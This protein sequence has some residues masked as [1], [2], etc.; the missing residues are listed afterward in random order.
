[1]L[2]LCAC[3]RRPAPPAELRAVCGISKLIERSRATHSVAFRFS[4]RARLG[5]LRIATPRHHPRSS[6]CLNAG[7]GRLAVRQASGLRLDVALTAALPPPKSHVPE[8]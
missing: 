2:G 6:P 4:E 5:C 1:A 3:L 8:K 7:A